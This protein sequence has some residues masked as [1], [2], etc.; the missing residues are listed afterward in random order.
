[1]ADE[2]RPLPAV[3][4]AKPAICPRGKVT[5]KSFVFDEGAQALS[6][7]SIKRFFISYSFLGI[8][9]EKLEAPFSVPKPAKAGMPVTFDF[10]VEFALDGEPVPDD[11]DG[12]VG[13][14]DV[15]R[16]W[17]AMVRQIMQQVGDN[18]V[19]LK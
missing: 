5:I 9:P 11:S 19:C 7:A 18:G 12:V 10:H 1:M 17:R 14:P 13:G 2:P 6:N 3:K 8:D 15:A 4:R 16:A